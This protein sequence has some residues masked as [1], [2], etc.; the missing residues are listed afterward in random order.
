[1]TNRQL[2]L[3]LK[4]FELMNYGTKINKDGCNFGR[5]YVCM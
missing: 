3:E 5:L 1:M 2:A 4:Y